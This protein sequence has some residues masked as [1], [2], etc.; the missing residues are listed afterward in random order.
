MLR[1]VYMFEWRKFYCGYETR[2]EKDKTRLKLIYLPALPSSFYEAFCLAAGLSSIF[3]P[4][5]VA[6]Q[7]KY[8]A[9][10][11]LSLTACNYLPT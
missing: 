6:S 5:K 11:S 3:V 8:L 10:L 9:P 1:Q 7:K 4:E 2:Q